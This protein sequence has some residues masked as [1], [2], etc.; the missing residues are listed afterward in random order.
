MVFT[1]IK[2]LKTTLQIRL[3]AYQYFQKFYI[4]KLIA[5][6]RDMP[7]ITEKPDSEKN[8]KYFNQKK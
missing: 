6:R 4:F 8:M 3:N 5:H 2:N 7:Q 1:H